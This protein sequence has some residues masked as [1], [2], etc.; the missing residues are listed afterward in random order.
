V[1]LEGTHVK[2]GE[3]LLENSGLEIVAAVDLLDAAKKIV[4]L[5]QEVV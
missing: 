5:V 4:S 1:R 2:E 3:A